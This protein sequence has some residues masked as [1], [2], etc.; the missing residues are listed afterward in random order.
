MKFFYIATKPNNQ[1]EFLIHSK[2]CPY[3]PDVLER[4]YLGPFN[5]GIEALR[6]AQTNNPKAACCEHCTKQV[7]SLL[8]SSIKDSFQGNTE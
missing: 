6:V 5:S 2:N 8:S 1:G 7:D 3:L 4:D